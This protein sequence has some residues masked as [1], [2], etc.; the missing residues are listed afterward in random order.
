M[1]M[2]APYNTNGQLVNDWSTTGAAIGQ[3]LPMAVG[4]WPSFSGYN[5]QGDIDEFQIFAWSL[6]QEEVQA[7]YNQGR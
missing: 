5:F 2:M 6:T 4:A 1:A 3:G 7:L